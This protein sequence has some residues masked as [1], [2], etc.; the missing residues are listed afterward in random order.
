M[1]LGHYSRFRGGISKHRR[2]LEFQLSNHKVNHRH[3]SFDCI[4]PSGLSF[5]RLNHAVNSLCYCV[6]NSAVKV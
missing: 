3:E 6:G 4:E 5:C 1:K 2:T